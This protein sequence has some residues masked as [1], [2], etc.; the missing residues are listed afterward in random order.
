MQ[1][2]PLFRGV[3]IS[4]ELLGFGVRVVQIASSE[5]GNQVIA[6]HPAFIGLLDEPVITEVLP[7]PAGNLTTRWSIDT[8]FFL[9]SECDRR[10]RE[11]DSLLIEKFENKM[12][13]SRH[14]R[15]HRGH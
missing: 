5:I 14:P 10:G 4:D 1:N 6:S 3:H 15:H 12:I 2:T 8:M 7:Q 9:K 11:S 13:D